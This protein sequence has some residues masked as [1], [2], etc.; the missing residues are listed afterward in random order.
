MSRGM[1][2]M[3]ISYAKQHNRRKIIACTSSIG[4][5]GREIW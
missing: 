3:A 1:A 5:G 2:H 4:P